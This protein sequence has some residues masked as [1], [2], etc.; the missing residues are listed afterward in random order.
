MRLRRGLTLRQRKIAAGYLFSLPFVLGF[1]FFFLYPFIQ[2]FIFSVSELTITR[3][4]FDLS[5]KALGN[6]HY[7]INVHTTFLRVFVETILNMLVN[8]PLVLAFS[9]FAAM[10]IN[11]KFKGRFLA[12]IIFFLPVIMSA[13][14]II[15]MD[16]SDMIS[17]LMHRAD[18]SAFI[19]GGAGLRN[20]LIN[21]ELPLPV[22]DFILNAVD[23]IPDI[24]NASGIQILI[25]LAGLQSI[26]PSI[27]EAAEVEGASRWECFWLITLPLLSPILIANAVYTIIDT[28][29]TPKNEVVMLIREVSIRGTGY[30]ISMAM[31]VMY[32]I[33]ILLII[34]ILIKIASRWV[35]YQE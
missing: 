14:I 25:F 18:H 11:Q 9:F 26:S 20:F 22:I 1:I 3:E 8:V 27:Y 4:G 17:Q 28:F 15:Q 2:A 5:Y 10:I 12:R 16:Q 33:T 7:A 32:F 19:F 6:Y 34:G 31:A 35:F 13:G 23:R 21:T 24:I 30:G 29:T